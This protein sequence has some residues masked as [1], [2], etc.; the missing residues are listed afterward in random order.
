MIWVTVGI[1]LF[2]VLMIALEVRKVVR[3]ETPQ[4]QGCL[5][6]EDRKEYSGED[7][8]ARY[9]YRYDA[10]K[11]R[12]RRGTTPPALSVFVNHPSGAEFYI[13]KKG[14]LNALIFQLF[15]RRRVKTHHPEL[16]G[17]YLIFAKGEGMAS[18]FQDSGQQ[19]VLQNLFRFGF[20]EM[21]YDGK[22]LEL[23]WCPFRPGDN[24]QESSLY[25][26]G[27][28]LVS[29]VKKMPLIPPSNRKGLTLVAQ[30]GLTYWFSFVGL[31]VGI[32][33]VIRAL[34]GG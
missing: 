4:N 27:R 3:G 20:N 34:R 13:C 29:F 1:V 26:A 2:V 10:P 33:L 32:L 17:N 28:S 18:C 19:S 23:R 12:G 25:E 11:Y 22:R 30:M 14:R 21:R 6:L 16:D 5:P 15:S 9:C 24:F 31:L 8:G 7:D